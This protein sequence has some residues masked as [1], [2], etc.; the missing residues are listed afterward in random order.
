GWAMKIRL[1]FA[2]LGVLLSP[3]ACSSARTYPVTFVCEADAGAE[4]PDGERCPVV[5]E[6]PNACGDLPEVL[7]HPSM[8]IDEARPAG[9][10]VGLSFGNP[11][12]G[13]SQVMCTCAAFASG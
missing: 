2:A 13:D 9:C 6:G 7:G 4:C 11:A 3:F 8:P 1:V 12:Y 5:P 10:R